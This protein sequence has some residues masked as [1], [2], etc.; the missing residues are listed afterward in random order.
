MSARDVAGHR[1][2]GNSGQ[3]GQAR[4]I[5]GF[6]IRR[7][8]QVLVALWSS[9]VSRTLTSPQY[10]VLGALHIAPSSD[11]VTIGR[12]AALDRSTLADVL[13]RLSARGLVERTRDSKDGRRKL[14]SL[15][16]A[17]RE[18][19]EAITPLADDVDRRLLSGLSKEQQEQFLRLLVKVVKAGEA[20]VSAASPGS[21]A[22]PNGDR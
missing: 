4:I 14:V 19:Y 21:R 5:P 16:E 17:G 20:Q 6:L 13:D 15:T 8:Q 3:G 10:A 7:A 18:T 22:H 1:R 11:Q 2:A 12:L 9:S